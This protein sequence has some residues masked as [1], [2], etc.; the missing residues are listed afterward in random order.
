MENKFNNFIENTFALPENEGEDKVMDLKEAVERH[1]HPGANIHVAVTHC[2]SY[3]AV[4][5]IARRF[6][7][8][9]PDFTLIMRGI[10]DTVIILLHMGLIKKVITAFSGNVYPSYGPNPICQKAYAEKN[11]ELEEWTILSFPLRLMA[12]ALGVPAMPT[13]SLLGSSLAETNHQNFR[14]I[15]DPFGT[16]RPM[17]L[18]KA[19]NPDISIVHGA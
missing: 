9:R 11:V 18:V 15:D 12:G 7:G 14:K 19:L 3:A 16:D 10:R 13:K 6:H 2:C 5:E 4:L 17:G 1:I 8:T